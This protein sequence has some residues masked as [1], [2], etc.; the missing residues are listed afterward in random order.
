M[1]AGIIPN[2]EQWIGDLIAKVCYNNAKEYL[3][4]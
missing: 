3:G 2:D 1:K 4:I